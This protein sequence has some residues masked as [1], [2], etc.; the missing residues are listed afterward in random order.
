[1]YGT[2]IYIS[3]PVPLNVFQLNLA[4]LHSADGCFGYLSMLH[5]LQS[6]H[7][8]KLH[9]KMIMDDES[10]DMEGGNRVLFK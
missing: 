9:I 2:S 7:T 5:L 4:Y 3:S 1:M 6:L 10:K 8:V